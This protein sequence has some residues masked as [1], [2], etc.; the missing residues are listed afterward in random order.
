MVRDRIANVIFRGA[1]LGSMDRA[2]RV[3]TAWQGSTRVKTNSP[4]MHAII[5]RLVNIKVQGAHLAAGRAGRECTNRVVVNTAAHTARLGSTKAQTG[6]VAAM[7]AA[8]GNTKIKLDKAA[9]RIVEGG[10]TQARISRLAA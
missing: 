9:A 10:N 4:D 6:L 5:V 2:V 3:P 7:H 1:M 8:S